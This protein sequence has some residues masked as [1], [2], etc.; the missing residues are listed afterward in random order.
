MAWL[1]FGQ[2]ASCSF[3][4]RIREALTCASDDSSRWVISRWLISSEKNKVGRLPCMAAWDAMPRAKAVLWVGTRFRPARNRCEGELTEMHRTGTLGTASMP[5]TFH[6]RRTGAPDRVGARL[7]AFRS[8]WNT[9][10]SGSQRRRQERAVWPSAAGPTCSTIGPHLW[11]RDRII[12]LTQDRRPLLLSPSSTWPGDTTWPQASITP[13]T[14]AR[15]CF[16]EAREYRTMWRAG[17]RAA[18]AAL[19]GAFRR[20]N[21]AWK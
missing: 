13:W 12:S 21:S 11:P 3:P 6:S 20:R 18:M 17:S 5:V 9:W 8:N 14:R 1:I 2:S 10:S 19:A 7:S 16:T 15:R 4:L